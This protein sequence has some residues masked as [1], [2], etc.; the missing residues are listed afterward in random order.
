[1]PR[2]RQQFRQG[3][4][5]GRARGPFA[6]GLHAWGWVPAEP[7]VA[8]EDTSVIGEG[9]LPLVEQYVLVC[10]SRAVVMPQ[11]IWKAV[12]DY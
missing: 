6:P 10:P 7:D 8:L 11:G 9:E 2:T 12:L 5:V 1:M 3:G 4:Q